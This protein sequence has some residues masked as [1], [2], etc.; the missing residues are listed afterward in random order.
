MA[1][2]KS[3]RY[4]ELPRACILPPPRSAT[5]V[6][7]L[8]AHTIVPGHKGLFLNLKTSEFLTRLVL[9]IPGKENPH[10][11]GRSAR[12]GRKGKSVW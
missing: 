3:P 10:F 5:G 12:Q 7:M 6:L 4:L 1:E 2:D 11:K 8:Q 9:S